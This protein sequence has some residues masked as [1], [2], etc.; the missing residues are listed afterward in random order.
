MDHDKHYGCERDLLS[1]TLAGK[2]KVGIDADTQRL[3]RKVVK[4]LLELIELIWFGKGIE[5]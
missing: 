3:S 2:R 4:M 1:L 5:I